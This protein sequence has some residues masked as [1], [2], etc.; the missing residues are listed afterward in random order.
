MA[1]KAWR[2]VAENDGVSRIELAVARGPHQSDTLYDISQ[3]ESGI[4]R[5]EP[6]QYYEWAHALKISLRHLVA[7]YCGTLIP[8]PTISFGRQLASLPISPH[9]NNE[10]KSSR[11][12]RWF[13]RSPS[14]RP[15]HRLLWS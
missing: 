6:H 12:K 1:W 5:I 4:A 9:G 3:L 11:G 7:S 10:L 13:L 15:G 14:R 2:L 8:S